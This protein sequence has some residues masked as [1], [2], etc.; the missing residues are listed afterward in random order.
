ELDAVNSVFLARDLGKIEVVDL[1]GEECIVKRPLRQ[2]DLEVADL[3]GL[4]LA[5]GIC[6][7]SPVRSETQ[8]GSARERAFQEEAT[9]DIG[10][11]HRIHLL[12]RVC[13]KHRR[14]SED[15]ILSGS[16]Y[17]FKDWDGIHRVDRT[18]L[19]HRDRR[20]GANSA[21]IGAR[22]G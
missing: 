20:S 1:L 21:A 16:D 6:R 18:G 22:A 5:R 14:T 4:R 7:D 19:L 17:R 12:T 3:A 2:G 11:T 10:F 15:R 9:T 13:R 8:Q